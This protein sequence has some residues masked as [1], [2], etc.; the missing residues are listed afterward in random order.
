M[1][2]FTT[3]LYSQLQALEAPVP[4]P[5]AWVEDEFSPAWM[6]FHIYAFPPIYLLLRVLATFQPSTCELLL[7]QI[8]WPNHD[9]LFYSTFKTFGFLRFIPIS[10]EVDLQISMLHILDFTGCEGG[11]PYLVAGKYAQDFGLIPE[12]CNPYKGKDGPCSE[13]KCTRYYTAEYSY[14]GGFYG[15]CNEELMRI[16]LVKNGPLA[17]GFEVYN[18]FMYY[19]SGIY[20]HTGLKDTLNFFEET[21]HAVLLVGYGVSNGEKFWIVKNSWG[22]KWGENGFFRIRRG[23]DECGF[24]SMAMEATPIP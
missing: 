6:G 14:V 1:I 23:T 24:E 9:F 22:S 3:H 8:G 20:H 5:Q 11:F 12:K 7:P 18:D 19:S 21:N 4:H 16:Q 2:A 13:K 15:A 17:V 10:L